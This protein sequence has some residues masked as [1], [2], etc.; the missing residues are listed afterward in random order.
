MGVM[1]RLNGIK[2][3]DLWKTPSY[4]VKPLLPYLKP[5]SHI[6]C[7]FDRRESAFVETLLEAGHIVTRS[8]IDYGE[9][10]F[11]YRPDFLNVDYIISNPPYSI[12]DKVF[13]HL[14]YLGKPFAMLMT[15]NGLFEGKRFDLFKNKK[16]E[17][18]WLKPRVA[19]LD[20]TGKPQKSP[21]FA[22]CYVCHRV[23]PKAHIFVEMEK[24]AR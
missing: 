11:D 24:E 12:K 6:L 20:E 14:F 21:P 18:M 23:L 15:C 16:L 5:G 10:F 8:H 19:F 22:S 9:D 13:E 1:N 17:I 2:L 7:P 4:A 3:N